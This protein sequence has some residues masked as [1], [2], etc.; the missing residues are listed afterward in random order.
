MV[1]G[2][3]GTVQSRRKARAELQTEVSASEIKVLYNDLRS[4]SSQPSTHSRSL[5]LEGIQFHRTTRGEF[6][7]A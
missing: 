5:T 7:G 3:D 2:G 1:E 4:L 6:Q